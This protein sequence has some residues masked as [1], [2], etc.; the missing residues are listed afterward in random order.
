MKILQIA[1]KVPYPVNDGGRGG[2]FNI[3]HQFLK[4]GAEVHFAA[5]RVNANDA[6]GFS[7]LVAL[8]LLDVDP[9]NRVTGALRNLMTEQPYNTAKYYSDA[10][11]RQLQ[12]IVRQHR[13]DIIHVDS[14]HMAAYG[15]AL[16]RLFG[17]P[18]S[19]REHNV[20]SEI[21]RHFKEQTRNPLLRWY[22]DIQLQ[23]LV[24]YEAATVQ[25]FGMVVPISEID[26]EKLARRAHAMKATVIPAG[27]DTHA[28]R[29]QPGA[30]PTN[31][32]FLTNYD[33]LPNRDSV[34]YYL[35]EIHPK[36]N[37][38][39]P[40]VK[41]I[42]VGKETDRIKLPFG[43]DSVEARGFVDDLNDLPGLGR[44][45]VVPLRIGSGIRI[46]ILELM[47]LGMPIVS[48]SLGVEGIDARDG[49]HI[50]IVDEP[51]A[52]AD[53]VASLLDSPE[54]CIRIG[55]NAR[56]LVEQSFSWD[57]VGDRFLKCY[58]TLMNSR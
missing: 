49:E 3:T 21:M 24:R 33:W 13:F 23:K 26:K 12:E 58:A 10:S 57:S 29:F 37:R 44:V 9:T 28:L 2:I 25:K 15:I 1:S 38:T 54:E 55:T 32:V 17:I 31:V 40:L 6:D 51:Q 46:K 52:F 39:S 5:P 8:H 7:K 16:G 47:A 50:V 27:V 4:G 11:L 18:I 34:Q 22:A 42:F 41:T 14:L 19:L 20:D 36:L 56:K 30:A 45:A 43:L 35:Q 53:A 48:T